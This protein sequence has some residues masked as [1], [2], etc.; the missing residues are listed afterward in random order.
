MEQKFYLLHQEFTFSG[1]EMCPKIIYDY[2]HLSFLLKK[3]KYTK[4]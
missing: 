1:D 2:V 4:K 3:R